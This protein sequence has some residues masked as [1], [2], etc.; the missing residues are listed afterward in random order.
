MP[1]SPLSDFLASPLNPAPFG[2]LVAALVL[3]HRDGGFS[4]VRALLGRGVD[5]RFPKV[6]LIPALLL[7]PAVVLA[8]AAIGVLGMD[9]ITPIMS[10][11]ELVFV[12]LVAFVVVLLTAGPLQEEF[13][14]RG[15]AL[16]RLQ[17]R[18]GALVSSVVLGL[19][20][21]GWHLPLFWVYAGVP[22]AM[23]YSHPVWVMFASVTLSSIVF[24]WVYNN[25]NGS[26]LSALLLHTSLNLS[27]WLIPITSSVLATYASVAL[28]LLVAIVIVAL[29]GH[30]SFRRQH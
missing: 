21:T 19:L 24:T 30:A 17:T 28:L 1:P 2:P 7:M 10:A 6:W 29:Y 14:W 12:L 13:G 16:P 18:F 25:T 3:T 5:H 8:S 11:E 27:L 22:N 9:S 4:S 23:Y 15:Y 26:V 20:W